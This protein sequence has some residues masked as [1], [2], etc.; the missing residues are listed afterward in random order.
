MLTNTVL[1]V[2]RF[3]CKFYHHVYM[4][5][6]LDKYVKKKVF[7]KSL[8]LKDKKIIFFLTIFIAPGSMYIVM[9]DK[10]DISHDVM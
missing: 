9:R 10:E 8:I 7:C 5:P 3:T 1:T 2:V 6:G 4:L